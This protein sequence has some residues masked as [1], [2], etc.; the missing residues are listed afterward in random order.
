MYDKNLIENFFSDL[1]FDEEK[2]KYYVKGRPLDLSVSGILKYF[3]N[4]FKADVTAGYV[5]KARGITK[6]QVLHEWREAKNLSLEIGNRSHNFGEF[7]AFNRDLIPQDGYQQ[8]IVNFWATVPEHVEVVCCEYRMY[9]K[10]KWYGG[11]LDILLYNTLTNTFIIGDYKTNKDLHKNH[12]GQKLRGRFNDLLDTPYDKYKIQL[13]YYH[14]M[15]EQIPG[16]KVS[17]RKI[18]WIKPDG[19][20]E[21]LDCEDYQDRIR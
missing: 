4:P 7:Y 13:N 16:V 5:A 18:I 10:T 21:I 20:F 14:L 1:Q 2:H 8:A 6:G 11:T 3:E 12:K 15:L 17:S 9:H 19:N